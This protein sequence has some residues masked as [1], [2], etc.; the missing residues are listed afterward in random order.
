MLSH[1]KSGATQ[2]L[3]PGR[4]RAARSKVLGRALVG[5]RDLLRN[6]A[7]PRRASAS[8]H[9]HFDLSLETSRVGQ[10]EAQS[11]HQLFDLVPGSS[12]VARIEATV[13]QNHPYFDLALESSRNS[14]IEA[15]QTLS[16]QQVLLDRLFP[17]LN[18]MKGSARALLVSSTKA[19]NTLLKTTEGLEVEALGMRRMMARDQLTILD[20]TRSTIHHLR[21]SHNVAIAALAT[22]LKFAE[23]VDKEE[24]QRVKD[25][26]CEV[27]EKEKEA[28]ARVA[29]KA[30]LQEAGHAVTVKELEEAMD[31]HRTELHE[32]LDILYAQ[33]RD[34]EQTRKNMVLERKAAE[35]DYQLQL[36]QQS[37]ENAHM[38]AA[39]REQ[40]SRTDTLSQLFEEVQQSHQAAVVQAAALQHR[41]E[42]TEKYTSQ[43]Q[44]IMAEKMA[45]MHRL[46][47][48]TLASSSA[49]A[50]EMR[51][52]R[53]VVLEERTARRALGLEAGAESGVALSRAQSA[54]L[55]GGS[56]ASY[57]PISSRSPPLPSARNASRS[58]GLLYSDLTKSRFDA[59]SPP[60]S[61][62]P[63]HQQSVSDDG[64]WY[65]SSY[66]GC[67]P[68]P[69]VPAST[70]YY[71]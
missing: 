65:T 45:N 63:Q 32:Q 22:D 4:G 67:S 20:D 15:V 38:A 31:T 53:D 25:R 5:K 27:L 30:A 9:S 6:R 21:A 58:R 55:L 51:G 52:V 64:S 41:V 39:L 10:S 59:F 12:Q 70:Y 8:G 7:T 26:L 50:L 66:I 2:T 18:E 17:C 11:S 61:R 54:S 69:S 47:A 62:Q 57:S 37:E 43:T 24:C 49:K 16:E 60:V 42:Q 29:E 28:K 56:V 19:V 36:S 46:Q 71:D 1:P 33:L 3:S 34:A 68:T 35:H 14:R 40:T 13:Q 23:V 48:W 44:A